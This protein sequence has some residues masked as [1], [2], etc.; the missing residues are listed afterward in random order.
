MTEISTKDKTRTGKRKP[1]ATP[2]K[3]QMRESTSNSSNAFKTK[4]KVGVSLNWNVQ[5][6]KITTV[7]FRSESNIF[8]KTV[9]PAKNRNTCVHK[10]IDLGLE[11]G[12]LVFIRH[13]LQ[14]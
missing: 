12:F 2:P 4:I 9:W 5:K 10:V 7:S 11:N 1:P 13:L 3:S 6:C 14:F 8:I